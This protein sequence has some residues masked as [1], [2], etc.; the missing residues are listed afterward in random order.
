MRFPTL[1]ELPPHPPGKTG[2]PWTEASPQLADTMPNKSLLPKVSIV[3]P[4]FNQGQFIEETIRS[5]LLQGYPNLEYIIIDGGSTDN[6]VEIIK[7]YSSWLTYW[8]SEKDRG[9]SH[10]IN[11]GLDRCTGEVFNWINSDDRLAPGALTEV[12]NLWSKSQPHLLVGRGIVLESGSQC[13]IHDWYPKAP[14]EPLDFIRP[15]HVVMAQPSTF[16]STRLL[17]DVGKLREDLHYVMDW[18]VYLRI[19][20]LLR[21]ELRTST[22]PFL[23]SRSLRHPQAKTSR[24]PEDFHYEVRQVLVEIGSHLSSFER[25][26]VDAYL[27]R[28]NGQYL[29]AHAL[30]APNERLWQ[31]A[32]LPLHSPDLLISRFFWGAVRRAVSRAD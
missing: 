15:H 2:W 30:G 22:T 12:G 11:K 31:L 5:V 20:V 17:K 28:M 9:Q 25:F 14:V 1:T 18:E 21:D 29:V 27:R 4:S 19:T 6:S 26:R 24:Q 32:R 7:K 10:A 13:V 23:L 3:T 16:F 8:V